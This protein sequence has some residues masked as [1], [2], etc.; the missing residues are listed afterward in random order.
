MRRYIRDRLH[1]I[2][3]LDDPPHKLALAFALGVFIAFSPTLGLHIITALVLA[4][5]LRLSKIVILTGSFINNP[6]TIVPLYGFCTWFG[7]KITGSTIEVPQIPWNDLTILNAYEALK[8]Y[9]W[10]YVAGTLVLGTI[11][12]VAA[13]FLFYCAVLRYRQA[14]K[15]RLF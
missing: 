7:M 1:A 2:I 15:K 14:D 6:W 3:K 13:Y 11:A 4:W 10:A 9:L 5:V 8:P 12:A